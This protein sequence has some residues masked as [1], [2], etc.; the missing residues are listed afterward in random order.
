MNRET[1]DKK[2]EYSLSKSDINDM[3]HRDTN[4]YTTKE[5]DKFR[6][7]DE[8]FDPLGR[9]IILYLTEDD[10]TGHWIS[11]LKKGDTIEYYDPYGSHP[12]NQGDV[13]NIDKSVD[14]NLNGE[15]KIL[16][17]IKDAG[18]KVK[19]NTRKSQPDKIGINTCGRH[20]VFR[21]L[22]NDMSMGQYN[23]L[24]DS[25]ENKEINSDDLITYLT[26]N[27]TKK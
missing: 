10:H 18:Y 22:L 16:N 5:L 27:L 15:N 4:I 24:L 1:L 12:K 14:L 20:I 26:D 19:H 6:H 7:I 8:I 2:K 3:L 21:T 25:V 9:V 23:K 11:L 17:M 13:L